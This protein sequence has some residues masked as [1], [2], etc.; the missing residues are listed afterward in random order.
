MKKKKNNLV[1]FISKGEKKGKEP[2][3][4]HGKIGD[5]D[6]ELHAR[7]CVHIYDKEGLRFKKDALLFEDSL[8]ALNLDTLKDGEETFIDGSGDNPDLILKKKD[9]DIILF[10][11]KKG[12]STINKL[13]DLLKKVTRKKK[14]V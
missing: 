5:L 2:A 1:E 4:D 13:K 11:R 12:Y 6:Y 8:D 14:A 10:L 9:G 7:G 3:L